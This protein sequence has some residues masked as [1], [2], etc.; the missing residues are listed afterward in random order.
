MSQQRDD[1][2]RTS[3]DRHNWVPV[4]GLARGDLANF[5]ALTENL[6]TV[7]LT[8]VLLLVRW[9]LEGHGFLALIGLILT[10][11]A[12]RSAARRASAGNWWRRFSCSSD[13]ACIV[14]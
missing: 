1:L 9:G 6:A 12:T 8:I 7:V 11:L 5:I 10:G 14:L 13:W 3:D 4:C 2:R